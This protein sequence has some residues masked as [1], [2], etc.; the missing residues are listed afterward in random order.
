MLGFA[1]ALALLLA[2]AFSGR[3]LMRRRRLARLMSQ[4]PGGHASNAMQV[5]SFEDIDEKIRARRCPCGG[6]Y[7]VLGEGSRSLGARRLRIVRV[8]CGT[9]ENE[10]TIHF[11]VTE[12]FH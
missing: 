1:I 12:L 11:D 4:L 7:D 3:R 8:E 6:R 2:L 10:A 5:D 9:C